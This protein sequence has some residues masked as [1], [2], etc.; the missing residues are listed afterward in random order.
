ML[1]TLTLTGWIVAGYYTVQAGGPLR[2]LAAVRSPH[3]PRRYKVALAL[4]ALPIP[5]PVDELIAAALLARIARMS[6]EVD[7]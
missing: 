4:C 5:G 2:I 6:S 7:A 3:V 1:A